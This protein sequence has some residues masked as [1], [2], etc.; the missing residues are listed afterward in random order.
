MQ[1]FALNSPNQ[2]FTENIS[3]EQTNFKGKHKVRRKKNLVKGLLFVSINCTP[4]ILADSIAVRVFAFRAG[5]LGSIP[6]KS[7]QRL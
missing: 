7:Y 3:A 4:D 2:I 6:V 5:N 1:I